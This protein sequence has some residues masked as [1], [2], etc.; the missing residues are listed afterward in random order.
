M[1]GWAHAALYIAV[2]LVGPVLA[3]WVVQGMTAVQRAR[4]HATLGM[5]ILVGSRGAGRKPWPVGPWLAATTWRQLGFHLLALVTGV[6][7]GGLVAV[8]WLAPVAAIGYL[9]TG[10]P[11][12]AAAAAACLAAAG[13]LLVAPWLAQRVTAADEASAARALLGPSHREELAQRVESLA[14]AGDLVAAAD[15]DDAAGFE[16]DLHDGAQQRLVSLAMN[17]GLTREGFA[18]APEPVRQAIADAHHEA[19]A[20]LVELRESCPAGS[21]PPCSPT[22]GSTRP[23]PGCHRA[24]QCRSRCTWIGRILRRP[25]SRGSRISSSARRSP[26]WPSTQRPPAPRSPSPARRSPARE[27]PTTATAA[28]PSVGTAC[29]LAG[30]RDR[31]EGVDGWMHV[32][33]PSAGRPSLAELPCGS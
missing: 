33:S 6:A 28:P 30:L 3:L 26:T 15:A 24:P 2:V 14:A 12:A 5:T 4:L 16:R 20:A 9:A 22:G 25:A 32:S 13:L 8:C 19:E 21:T 7:G 23:A 1:G 11:P 10:H 29:G 17:L 27:S 31:V 18:S